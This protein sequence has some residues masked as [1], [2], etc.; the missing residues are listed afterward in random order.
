MLRPDRVAEVMGGT[1]TLGARVR[2]AVDLETVVETGLP[3]RVLRNVVGRASTSAQHARRLLY[4]VVPEATYKRRT[5][6]TAR[7]CRSSLTRPLASRSL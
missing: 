1:K 7:D 5:R 4:R 6:L 3:K 2:S